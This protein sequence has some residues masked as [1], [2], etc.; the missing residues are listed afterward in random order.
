MRDSPTTP[1]VF[2]L[3]MSQVDAL[4]LSTQFR[5]EP[6]DVVYVGTSDAVRFNRVLE[7]ITPT[8]QTLFFTKELSR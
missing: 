2:R 3:D 7:Q 6:L 1:E 8:I 4:L 5:L